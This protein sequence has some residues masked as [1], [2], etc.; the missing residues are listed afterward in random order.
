MNI[1]LSIF[2]KILLPSLIALLLFSFYLFYFYFQQQ[3]TDNFTNRIQ[4]VHLPV[5]QLANE[6]LIL[7][8]NLTRTFKDAVGANEIAWLQNTHAARQTL[9]E[10]LQ[11][12]HAYLPEHPL[13]QSQAMYNNF[14]NYYESAYELSEL[15]IKNSRKLEKIEQL[16]KSMTASL[17]KTKIQYSAFF[18][19]QQREL[20]TIISENHKLSQ[21]ILTSGVA[22]GIFSIFLML[23][24]SFKFSLSTRKTITGLIVSLT[25]MAKGRPN[26][27]QRL[28]QFSQD[29]LGELVNSFNA[30]TDK[31]EQE[32][33]ELFF[34]K[35]K[36]EQSNQALRNSE[37][38]LRLVTDNSPAYIAYVDAESLHYLFVNKKFEIAYN[39]PR[40]QIIGQHIKDIIGNDNY[41][42]ALKYIEQVRQGKSVSYINTFPLETG[43]K[44][45]NVNYVPG[46]DEQGKV[47]AIVVLSHD[48]TEI[49]SVQEELKVAKDAAEAANKAKSEFLANMSHEIRTPLNAVLGFSELLSQTDV[50]NKQES[51][52]KSIKSGGKTLLKLINDIL[53]LSKVEAGKLTLEPEPSLIRNIFEDICQIFQ[54]RAE[55][56]GLKMLLKLDD[57]VP[58][59]LVLDEARIRQVL[60]NLVGNA[61]KFTHQGYI[62]ISVTAENYAEHDD[63]IRLKINVKDTGIGI[64]KDQQHKIFGSFEQQDGQSNRQYGGT[65][66]G[67]SI[68][69]KLVHIMGGEISLQSSIGE[70]SIFTIQLNHVQTAE[71]IEPKKIHYHPDIERIQ[72]QSPTILIVDNI[73]SNRQL[74][75]GYL[76]HCGAK[77]LEAEDGEQALLLCRSKI[78]DLV[79]M[80]IYMPVMDG[81]EASRKIIDSPQLKQIP[82]I[83]LTASTDSKIIEDRE[84]L[85]AAY[86]TKPISSTELINEIMQILPYSIVELESEQSHEQDIALERESNIEL[87]EEID[88]L[89]LPYWYQ[90]KKSGIFDD[91][92][93]FADALYKVADKHHLS[94]LKQLSEKIKQAVEGFEVN[95]LEGL[96]T[97]FNNLMR[98]WKTKK[99]YVP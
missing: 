74:I 63:D 69:K 67:L 4:Q 42:Y 9:L 51:Y 47:K 22:L 17:A 2:Q 58:D 38:Q 71:F 84:K 89:V 45:I 36:L 82:I 12:L 86:L 70:G 54:P 95:E 88:E 43:K 48:I 87:L 92:I 85:F 53:D 90:A 1:R 97:Q 23:Y 75:K 98:H 61:I 60:F 28:T 57:E 19:A 5:M 68:C 24:F 91:A 41:Q 73:D 46:F 29:E 56:K 79:L 55:E 44:W 66:L 10:N 77:F 81:M 13:V 11:L 37:H 52:L 32:H 20:D 3:T 16:S 59:C 94:V 65:G 83:A 72:F 39:I 50:N 80:D 93:I 8:D 33:K 26:F 35:Q 99:H 76:E 14:I 34:A 64:H 7:L 31:L 21:K 40:E 30:F 15:M 78:P 27:S 62:Q 96:Y 49:K 18:K 6:N 25:D